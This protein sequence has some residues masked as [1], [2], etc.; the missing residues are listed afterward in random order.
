MAVGFFIQG[1]IVFLPGH[2]AFAL[3]GKITGVVLPA[4]TDNRIRIQITLL[5]EMVRILWEIPRDA[6]YGEFPF[7]FHDKYLFSPAYRAGAVSAAGQYSPPVSSLAYGG[8]EH[9]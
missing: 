4:D 9:K 5:N 1:K 8:S 3:V 2:K 7:Y 6:A